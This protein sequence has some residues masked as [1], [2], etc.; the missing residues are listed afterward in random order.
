MRMIDADKVEQ[1]YRELLQS[2]FFKSHPFYRHGA[3]TLMDVC[4]RTDSGS[5]NTIDAVQV[6]RCKDCKYFLDVEG[7]GNP[8]CT[9]VHG[10]VEAFEEDYCSCG[11]R[12][13]NQEVE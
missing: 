4:V 9:S 6:V 12:K 5:D 2:P 11:E 3:G 7:Y 13:E 1:G 8:N 10:M